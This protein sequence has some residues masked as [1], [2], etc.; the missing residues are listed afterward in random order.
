MYDLSYIKAAVSNLNP[1][2]QLEAQV[3]SALEAL[4]QFEPYTAFHSYRVGA[5]A[6]LIAVSLKLEAK[7][8]DQIT[9]G[10]MLH[11]IGKSGVSLAALLKTTALDEDEYEDIKRHPE[12]GADLVQSF[13]LFIELVPA[14]RYHHERFDG[15]GY[16]MGLKGNAIPLAAR[17]IAVADTYDA[18]TSNR[19]YRTARSHDEAMRI[20]CEGSGSQFDPQIIDALMSC[21][22]AIKRDSDRLKCLFNLNDEEFV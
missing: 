17:V 3:K 5:I 7:L 14:I 15:A 4:R 21:E 22:H 9:A 2:G 16:P 10:G 12:I 11:D 20:L 13:P 19:S 6:K 18:V 8:I 1:Q